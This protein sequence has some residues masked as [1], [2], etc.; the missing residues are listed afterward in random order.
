MKISQDILRV[1]MTV[2]DGSVRVY[3]LS[4][5]GTVAYPIGSSQTY[6]WQISYTFIREIF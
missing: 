5:E 6:T 1:I 3:T 4:T 2:N